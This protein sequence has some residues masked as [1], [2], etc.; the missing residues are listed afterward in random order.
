M[1]VRETRYENVLR[2]AIRTDE[3]RRWLNAT[4]LVRVWPSLNPPRGV[5]QAWEA[6]N[7]QLRPAA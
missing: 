1:A 7:P 3:L 4:V 5:R 2:E 6:R